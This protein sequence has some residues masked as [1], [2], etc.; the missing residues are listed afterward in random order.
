MEIIAHR[1]AS[2]LAPENTLAS[3]RLGFELGAD[4]VE[5]DVWQS[6]D[7]RVVAIHDADTERVSGRRLV[8]SETSFE[9]LRAVEVGAWKHERFRGERI[10]SLEEVL[11][12]I[13]DGRRLFIEVKC[14]P[15]V[16]PALAGVLAAS[17]KGSEQTPVISFD[18]EVVR[19]VKAALPA[20]E[21]SFLAEWRPSEGLEPPTVEELISLARG[22]G[23]DGL[24][25]Q[26]PGPY[27][28]AFIA[29]IRAA[30]LKLY[31][32]TVD[33]PILGAELGS[34]GVD[35]ITTN[36]PAWMRRQLEGLE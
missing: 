20:L 31:V 29:K 2:Y 8:V 4:A 35:G 26:A 6:S 19:A 32:W 18:L 24:D 25:L 16:V 36:R 27:D 17:G 1:G 9:E 28:A 11:A 30:G 15:E 22:A 5:V 21:V 14:G 23:L 12:L 33:D 13:P 3:V 34:L 7:G 10:P